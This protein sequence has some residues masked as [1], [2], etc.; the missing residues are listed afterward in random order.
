M[1][2]VSNRE[3]KVQQIKMFCLFLLSV[4]YMIYSLRPEIVDVFLTVKLYKL[5]SILS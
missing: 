5:R 4:A 3:M 2:V 1:L